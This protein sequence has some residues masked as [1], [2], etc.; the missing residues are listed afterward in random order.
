VKY[1]GCGIAILTFYL[2]NICI[3]K[4][5]IVGSS[6]VDVQVGRRVLGQVGK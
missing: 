1:W 3:V 4:M 5:F 6:I 2:C